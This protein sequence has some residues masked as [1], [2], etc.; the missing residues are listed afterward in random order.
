M[1]EGLTSFWPCVITAISE[2]M[3]PRLT[4]MQPTAGFMVVNLKLSDISYLAILGVIREKRDH[5]FGNRCT[6]H[7]DKGIALIFRTMVTCESSH[8]E[9]MLIL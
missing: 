1:H 4:K 8:L 9:A 5:S 2:A 7:F 6:S 3:G